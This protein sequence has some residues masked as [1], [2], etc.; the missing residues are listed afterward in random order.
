MTGYHDAHGDE[1]ERQAERYAAEDARA[2]HEA[3][4]YWERRCMWEPE[5]IELNE[6][7][8]DDRAN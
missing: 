5:P 6:E 8:G 2:D 7:Q 3:D 4:A 1:P